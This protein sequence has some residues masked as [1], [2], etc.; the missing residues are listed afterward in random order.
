MACSC[1]TKDAATGEYRPKQ[2]GIDDGK[3]REM[4]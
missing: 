4:L 1:Q 3:Y 2:A